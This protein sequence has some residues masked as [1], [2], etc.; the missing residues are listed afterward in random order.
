MQN[1][2]HLQKQITFHGIEAVTG[3]APSLHRH[4]CPIKDATL[5][6]HLCPICREPLELPPTAQTNVRRRTLLAGWSRKDKF[7]LFL[8]ILMIAASLIFGIYNTR[9]IDRS[10]PIKPT[11]DLTTNK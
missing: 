11:L 2:K 1:L 8:L 9:Q 4:D 3:S 6:V 7:Y 10:S 5:F